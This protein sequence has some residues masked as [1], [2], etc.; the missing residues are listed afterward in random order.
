VAAGAPPGSPSGAPHGPTPGNTPVGSTFSA[1]VPLTA[2]GA[3]TLTVIATDAGGLKTTLT[4]QVTRDTGIPVLSLTSPAAGLVTKTASVAVSGTV[5][6]PGALMVAVNGIPLP[7]DGA[8]VFTGTWPLVEGVNFLTVTATDAAGNTATQVRQVTLDTQAP[9]V[10]IIAPTPGTSTTQASV[11]VSGTVTDATPVTVT[12]D[13]SAAAVANGSFSGTAALV[14]GPNTITVSAS[15]AAGNIG[16]ATVAL[17]RTQAGPP[18]PDP[19]TVAPP[20]DQSVQTNIG[21]ATAFL[22]AGSNPI[23]TGVAP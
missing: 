7:V 8:G 11:P 9:I 5:S 17:A 1:Q 3:N 23:Q 18:P 13:G 19:A 4:R 15:D 20:V 22:Y 12:I 10:A 21:M 2:E 14:V 16:T 6:D